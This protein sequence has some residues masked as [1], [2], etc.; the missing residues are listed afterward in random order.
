[1]KNNE[2]RGV[3]P[4]SPRAAVLIGNRTS[5]SGKTK[6]RLMKK[7]RGG[8]RFGST[9]L[10]SGNASLEVIAHE[11]KHSLD[12]D[13]GKIRKGGFVDPNSRGTLMRIPNY[14]IDAVRFE[15][16]IRN[17][18]YPKSHCKYNRDCYNDVR[19]PNK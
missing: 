12:F 5:W 11:I 7:A 16:L 17:K 18:I 2:I 13:L 1:M 4:P 3:A 15:N 19:L 10:L 9:T 6:N 8:K 14:E